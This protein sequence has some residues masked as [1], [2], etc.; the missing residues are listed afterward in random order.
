MIWPDDHEPP[1]VHIVR[2]NLLAAIVYLGV[3]GQPVRLRANYRLNRRELS[4][5]V[6]VVAANNDR[7]VEEWRNIHGES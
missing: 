1:H 3:N 2:G 4:V 6:R 5:A 7:F